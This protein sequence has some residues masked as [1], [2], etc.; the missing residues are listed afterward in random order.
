MSRYDPGKE[1]ERNVHKWL[2]DQSKADLHFAYHRLPD[3]RSAQGALGKQPADF[4][5]AQ[6]VMTV[7]KPHGLGP[8]IFNEPP[9]QI[10]H[11]RPFFLEVKETK[12][13]RRLPKDKIS[14]YGKL[15]MFHHAGFEVRVLVKRTSHRDWVCFT[16]EH[17]FCYETCP[18]SFPFAGLESFPSH[19][20]ALERIFS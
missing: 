20:D 1:A 3:A 16:Q 5:V 10:E 2:E 9:K 15:L 13:E 8:S 19:K 4:L 7:W 12:E 14:Q 17:L 6:K 18:S 11:C